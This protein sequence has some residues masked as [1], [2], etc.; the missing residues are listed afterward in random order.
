[1]TTPKPTLAFFG[2]TG[3]CALN[4]LALALKSG[5][6]AVARKKIFTPFPNPIN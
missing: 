3:G 6:K 5:Y 2:A 1:M 4:T